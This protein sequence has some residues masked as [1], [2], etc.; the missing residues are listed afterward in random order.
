MAKFKVGDVVR[1][2]KDEWH[3]M[4]VGDSDTVESA[5]EKIFNL[6]KF[7][8]GY[9]MENFE[10]VTP[11]EA[12]PIREVTKREFV[13]GAYGIVNV[14]RIDKPMLLPRLGGYA[15]HE[16]R[17]AA[18]TL[19]EISDYLVDNAGVHHDGN[20]ENYCVSCFGIAPKA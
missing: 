16:L 7:G 17:A 1:R 19:I 10:L 18:R 12:G 3:S 9:S 5:N 2:V 15:P 14:S 6:K 8:V 4:G 11:A 20:L 13:P